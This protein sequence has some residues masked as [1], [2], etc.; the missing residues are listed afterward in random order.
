MKFIKL[1]WPE[2][3]DFMAGGVHASENLFFDPDKDVWFVPEDE[4][5]KA[6]PQR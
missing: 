2:S 3:Q 4:Y 5:L 6:H 1:E